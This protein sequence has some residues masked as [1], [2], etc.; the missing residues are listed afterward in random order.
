MGASRSFRVVS[1]AIAFCAMAGDVLAQTPPAPTVSPDPLPDVPPTP[2][3]QNPFPYFDNY[4]WRSFIA[5]NWPGMTAA[6][7]RGQ[8]DRGKK[9]GDATGPRVWETWK[10]GYEIF[11]PGATPP[12]PWNSYDGA[13]PC[14]TGF[15]NTVTT[16][17]AFTEFGDFNQ[18]TFSLSKV[19]N[20]LV[21]QN[22]TYA[23]YEVRANQPEFDTIVQH[24]WYLADN[25]PTPAK[26]V[27]FAAASSEIKAAWRILT[28][29][30]TP[31]IRSR[32]YVVSGAQVFDVATK[33]CV[34]QDVALVGFHIVT[35]TPARPQWIWSTFEQVDNVPGL[36]S[37]PKPPAG[38]PLSFNDPA[39]PQKLDPTKAPPPISPTNPPQPSPAAMQVVRKQKILDDTMKMNQAYWD[40]PEIKGTVWQNYML[41]ATQWPTKIAPEQP[42]NDGSPFPVSGS[43]VANTT[44]ETYMQSGGQSCM[45]CHQISNEGGRDFVMFVTMNAERPTVAAPADLFAAKLA[46]G[47]FAEKKPSARE[48]DPVVEGLARFFESAQKQ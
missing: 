1:A 16:L 24:R 39:K 32:Y 22:Q 13:N 33:K 14:G 31:A 2:P 30:D 5:L 9:F 25:L 12:S 19:G 46:G 47:K 7:Q 11:Q 6:A 37:E 15:V 48:K 20:P 40:L 45:E 10:A 36:T 44:M 38:V 23:R 29:K 26:P 18:A 27:P 17:S 35:K 3:G 28:D 34:K 4:S 8:P 21:A 41:V 42:D 43:E